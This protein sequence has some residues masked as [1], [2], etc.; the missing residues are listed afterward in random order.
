ML[1]GCG[2]SRPPSD[3]VQKRTNGLKGEFAVPHRHG[4]EDEKFVPSGNS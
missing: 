4:K 2:E 1:K 3:E